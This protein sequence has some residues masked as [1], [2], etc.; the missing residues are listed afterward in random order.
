M[1]PIKCLSY[2]LLAVVA[3]FA[4]GC[5]GGGGG[6]GTVTPPV[7]PSAY[8]VSADS[9]E[10]GVLGGGNETP[11]TAT[12]FT[13]GDT[14]INSNFPPGDVDVYAVNLTSGLD[15]EFS[16]NR[17]CAT[18]DTAIR[19]IDR[20]MVAALDSNDDWVGLDS[21]IQYTPTVSGTYY[22][23]V[24]T[25]DTTY[26]ISTYTFGARELVDVDGDG[27]SSYYDCD[28]DNIAIGPNNDPLVNIEVGVLVGDGFD[29]T[30]TGSDV[31]VGTIPDA[32]ELDD[33]PG[34]A[35]AM[36]EAL[37]A[38]WEEIY[39]SEL[40]A[41]SGNLRTIDGAGAEDYMT[42]SVP[43]KGAI[44]SGVVRD[45]I[46]NGVSV[47]VYEPD[48]STLVSG[49][50]D[51]T[52]LENITGSAMTYYHKYSATNG[53]DTGAYVPYYF[54]LG[55]D[56]DD[57]GEYTQDWRSFRDCDDTDSSI[58]WGATETDGDGVDS[59]CDGYD[60]GPQRL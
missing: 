30:C 25:F 58:H 53:A 39:R 22:V 7:D 49:S 56:M 34:T 36:K 27:W 11:D 17:L 9:N 14:Q 47:A 4:S 8:P 38:P 21:A 42:I 32:H 33:T 1:N 10:Q 60:D 40:F 43:A 24:S 37:G 23:E 3:L 2:S 13:I 20:N 6:G 29:Q 50:N 59:N 54:S 31:P 28:D 48:G 12:A 44:G 46:P 51:D 35:V 26:G 16:A 19:L 15:Y 18:C 41:A 5:G 55:V 52:F 45:Y 57:D